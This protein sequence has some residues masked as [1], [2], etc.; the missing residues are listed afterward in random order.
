MSEPLDRKSSGKTEDRDKY[1]T[2]LVTVVVATYN[3]TDCLLTALDSLLQQDYRTYEI[4]VIDQSEET[5]ERKRQ[6]WE[7][8]PE[9]TV[10]RIDR[11]NRCRAKNTGVRLAKGE[12]V[13]I[14]DDDIIAPPDLI[15]KHVCHYADKQVGGGSCRIVEDGQPRTETRNVLKL[16]CYGRLINNA[17]STSSQERVATV[18]GGNMSFRRDLLV[19]GDM[20]FEERFIGTGILEEQDL[21][22]RIRKLG[23]RL[24]FDASTTVR[25]VPQ[26]TGNLMTLKQ[27]RADWHHDYFHNLALFWRKH[28]KY[29]RLIASVPYVVAAAV[30]Q[31]AKYRLPLTE[32]RRMIGGYWKGIRR[33]LG[34]V[35]QNT[36]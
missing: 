8:H 27:H 6:Y 36:P 31:T 14:C 18:N 10:H 9:I 25:H 23:Y 30:V 28:G 5:S 4:I 26:Q 15:A 22:W 7:A 29:L 35:S 32:L 34:T 11:P 21:A 13:L 1:N 17:H 16:T 24:F 3:R 12:I 19:G 33:D 2:P 20:R